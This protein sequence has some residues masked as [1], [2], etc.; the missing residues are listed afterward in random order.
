MLHVICICL[1]LVE[2]V[3]D[4][5]DP[6]HGVTVRDRSWRLKLHPAC[7]VGTEMVSWMVSSGWINSRDDAIMVGKMLME[8]VRQ[9][10]MNI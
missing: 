1:V 10:N 3:H 4:A 8:R 6:Y 2:L 5:K 7:F 9:H